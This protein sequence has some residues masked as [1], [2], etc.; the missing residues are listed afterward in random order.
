MGIGV[1]P[2]IRL[3]T[4]KVEF[5]H[6]LTNSKG[7]MS[8]FMRKRM[9]KLASQAKERLKKLPSRVVSDFEKLAEHITGSCLEEV[10]AE[11]RTVY[12]DK[13]GRRTYK[14]DDDFILLHGYEI[15][16]DP[17]EDIELP[18]DVDTVC[19]ASELLLSTVVEEMLGEFVCGETAGSANVAIANL[20]N[21]C[22]DFFDWIPEVD[23]VW[24]SL[25]HEV[26]VEH[27]GM[28]RKAY[29]KPQLRILNHYSDVRKNR[30]KLAVK[31]KANSRVDS[32]VLGDDET[33]PHTTQLL[34]GSL[35][36]QGLLKHYDFVADFDKARYLSVYK[37]HVK[38]KRDEVP[39]DTELG[40]ITLVALLQRLVHKS[41]DTLG[42]ADME[43]ILDVFNMTK[44][45]AVIS[46]ENFL[47]VAAIAE[48][49]AFVNRVVPKSESER[50]GAE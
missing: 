42:D 39:L 22:L 28:M 9:K 24:M 19:W 47:V 38:E 17:T 10:D 16:V 33:D 27:L 11:G 26:V 23:K 36:V 3:A 35:S 32:V 45:D 15:F 21:A 7:D 13:R 1:G 4:P 43:Y 31:V 8:M 18:I 40:Q 34:E 46:L 48:H 29:V 6:V 37:D 41:D 20:G 44:T 50:V 30:F 14:G 12:V 49:L 2:Q 25:V 5:P